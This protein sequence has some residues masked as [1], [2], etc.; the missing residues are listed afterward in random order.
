MS[1][2]V[3]VPAIPSIKQVTA[4]QHRLYYYNTVSEEKNSITFLKIN[5]KVSLRFCTL[6]N[7]H[8]IK[9]IVVHTLLYDRNYVI[10]IVKMHYTSHF[11]IIII[12]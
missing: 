2:S 7:E 12:I 8:F 11:S 1:T 4:L 6:V 5:L 10:S 9:N 3:H